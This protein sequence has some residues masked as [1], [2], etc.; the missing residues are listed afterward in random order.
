MRRRRGTP[1]VRDTRMPLVALPEPEL[2]WLATTGLR[3]PLE[4][5][6]S[7]FFAFKQQEE[8]SLGPKLN[9]LLAV[10]G[11]RDPAAQNGVYALRPSFTNA[12]LSNVRISS[13]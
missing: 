8:I 12:T 10:G 5:M 1:A 7:F 6:V 11:L 9:I 3:M 13:P 2:P 4:K